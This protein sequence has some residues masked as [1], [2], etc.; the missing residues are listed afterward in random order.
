M[1]T[2]E[3]TG[4][5]KLFRQILAPVKNI[6]FDDYCLGE[7]IKSLKTSEWTFKANS[8][9]EKNTMTSSDLKEIIESVPKEKKE[10]NDSTYIKL[11]DL[12]RQFVKYQE[13]M[14][15]LLVDVRALLLTCDKA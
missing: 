12:Y 11:S 3:E 13:D 7:I 5:D 10:S 1:S 6:Q 2:I 15:L 4:D 9:I 8:K 14:E